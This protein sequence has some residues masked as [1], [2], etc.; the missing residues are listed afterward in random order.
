MNYMLDSLPKLSMLAIE[1][2]IFDIFPYM[3]RSLIDCTP[4]LEQPTFLDGYYANRP[5][6]NRE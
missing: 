6:A 4:Y 3:K 2:R 5:P 1:A